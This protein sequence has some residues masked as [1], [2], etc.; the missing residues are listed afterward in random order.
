MEATIFYM[1][2]MCKF[3]NL[4][5]KISKQF[6]NLRVQVI[7]QK[8]LQIIQTKHKGINEY[9][10]NFPVDYNAIDKSEILNIYMYLMVKNNA[11]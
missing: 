8:G 6:N 9:V 3:I 7:F 5:Q 10:C 11:K 1:L 4:K 2:M